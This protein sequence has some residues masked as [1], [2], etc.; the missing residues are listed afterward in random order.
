[1]LRGVREPNVRSAGDSLF[2]REKGSRASPAVVCLHGQFLD[3]SMYDR[4]CE[5]LAGRLRVLVPDLPGYG[6]SPLPEPYSLEGVRA[7]IC[8]D[9][10]A[11]GIHEVAL[12]GASLGCYHALGVALSGEVRVS[13]MALLGPLAG[14]DAQVRSTFAG[15]ARAIADGMDFVGPT[16]SLALPAGWAE[17]NPGAVKHLRARVAEAPRATLVAELGALGR[18]ADLRPRLHEVRVPTLVR[19]GDS[20]ANTPVAWAEGIARAIPGATLQVVPGVGHLCLLQDAEATEG[21][22][23]EFLS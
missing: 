7:A 18:L 13:R 3:G 1:M 14:A 21:S 22:L 5:R 23:I 10:V 12:V 15:Y 17:G 9:L 19:V 20:D 4:L 16:L 11:R 8:R 2:W 6:G